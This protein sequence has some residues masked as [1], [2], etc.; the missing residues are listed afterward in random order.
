[1]V[2]TVVINNAL[3][4]DC[5]VCVLVFGETVFPACIILVTF[6]STFVKSSDASSIFFT[7]LFLIFAVLFNALLRGFK[8][9]SGFLETVIGSSTL[10]NI[11]SWLVMFASKADFPARLFGSTLVLAILKSRDTFGVFLA[12]SPLV[13]TFL[14]DACL[15]ILDSVVNPEGSG[16]EDKN[17]E[18]DN[19]SHRWRYFIK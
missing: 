8:G 12:C 17:S 14:F 18:S 9:D 16:N 11:N 1:L 13:G 3:D 2:H 19:G 4:V 10:G 5:S 7:S 15:R 6:V